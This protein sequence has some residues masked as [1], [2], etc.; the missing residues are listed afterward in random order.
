MCTAVTF[1][2]E[3]KIRFLAR[4][5]DFSFQLD[6]E[7][8]YIPRNHEFSS[9]IEGSSFSGEYAFMG[10]GRDI[11]GYLFADGFNEKGFGIATL[12]FEQNAQFSK[13]KSSKKLNIAPEELVSWALGNVS[14]VEDFVDKISKVNIIEQEN[15]FLKKNLPLHWIVSDNTGNTKVLEITKNG[16]HIYDNPV[17][18][19]T[20]SPEFPWHL[21]NLGHYNS[22][23]P[24]EHTPKTY[25]K[26]SPIPDGP[27]NGL[28]GIPGDFTAASRFIRAAVLRQYSIAAKGP[29]E[30]VTAI[31]HI[32]NAVDIPKGVKIT[33]TENKISDFTQ[34]KGIMDLTNKTYYMLSYDGNIL[35]KFSLDDKIMERDVPV[36]F[37]MLPD[38]KLM[39]IL[40][41]L[42]DFVPGNTDWATLMELIAKNR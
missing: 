9:Q 34:Y 17:G 10:A 13:R 18:V 20:N 2:T 25:G 4:T 5:M 15:K 41:H 37:P 22:L 27:G 14:S 21:T 40:D 19:M 36:V 16:E 30:G 26:F 42:T 7:P 3:D 8:I 32:L 33:D 24:D 39:G 35:H 6:A 12:Y 1:E 11:K 29:E 28:M 31:K 23:Q 38:N